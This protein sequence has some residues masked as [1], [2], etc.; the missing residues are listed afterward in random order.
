MKPKS[1]LSTSNV[2][3]RDWKAIKKQMLEDVKSGAAKV[4]GGTEKW[5]RIKGR[6]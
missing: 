3:K 4:H 5:E 6:K 2:E 1:S